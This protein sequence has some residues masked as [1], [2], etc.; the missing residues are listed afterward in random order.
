[1]ASPIT[2]AFIRTTPAN[3]VGSTVALQDQ[4]ERANKAVSA[5][6]NHK[7]RAEGN[8]ENAIKI[9]ARAV[10]L[11]RLSL[12]SKDPLLIEVTTALRAKAEGLVK[13]RENELEAVLSARQQTTS[14]RST[15]N[16][17]RFA[18][19]LPSAGSFYCARGID[20]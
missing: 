9:S 8:L 1:M 20:G 19:S 11:H 3:L 13:V 16:Q 6:V 4:L 17:S 7:R 5:N 12:A 14:A 10:R 15:S 2:L 18:K